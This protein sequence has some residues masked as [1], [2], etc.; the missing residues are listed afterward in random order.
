ADRA[1][2]RGR[3]LRPAAGDGGPRRRT[4]VHQA[5]RAAI[6]S[7]RRDG[8]GGDRAAPGRR[9]QRATAADVGT[10]GR[11][12]IAAEIRPRRDT[13]ETRSGPPSWGLQLNT[14]RMVVMQHRVLQ[15]IASACMLL[16]S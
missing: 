13:K 11:G 12:V 16:V 14:T 7:R 1:A 4:G 8:G 5:G 2:E 10:G 9:A 6:V 3:V 15:F